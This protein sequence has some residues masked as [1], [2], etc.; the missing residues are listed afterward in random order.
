MNR[1]HP[2]FPRDLTHYKGGNPPP[3]PPPIP[4]VTQ[5]VGDSAIAARNLRERRKKAYGMEDTLLAGSS[6]GQTADK[7]SL[8]G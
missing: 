4:P 8:L 5:A 1:N 6:T 3:P 7:Q 2:Y